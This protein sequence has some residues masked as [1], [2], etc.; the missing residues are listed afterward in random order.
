MATIIGIDPGKSGAIACMYIKFDPHD[1]RTSTITKVCKCPLDALTMAEEIRS[2]AINSHPICYMEKVNA[3]PGQGVK[4]VWTFA[5]NY[6]MWK[7]ILAALEIPLILVSPQK[8]QK[9]YGVMPKVKAV[10]L[11]K[12]SQEKTVEK[13]LRKNHLVTLARQRFPQL[14]PPKY[15]CD[16]LLIAQYGWDMENRGDK[17]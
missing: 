1:M 9:H 11:K 2:Y 4:S 13:R 12:S 7:G 5:E 8:W 3:W 15:A 6:G 16:A 10:G 14:K 17:E